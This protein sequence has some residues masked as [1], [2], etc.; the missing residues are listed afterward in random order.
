MASSL[1]AQDN[2]LFRQLLS[3]HDSIAELR[4]RQRYSACLD[5]D[6]DEEEDD[7]DITEC[8]GH[9]NR[10]NSPSL[11]S[12]SDP[13]ELPE[14]SPES[15]LSSRSSLSANSSDFKPRKYHNPCSSHRNRY[16]KEDGKQRHRATNNSKDDSRPL[17]FIDKSEICFRC[18]KMAPLIEDQVLL[19]VCIICMRIWN[20]MILEFICKDLILIL[21]TKSSY[22]IRARSFEVYSEKNLLCNI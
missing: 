21:I 1:I 10:H 15:T 3:L 17:I 16:R 20:P 19:L 13:G 14:T 12:L 18:R 2:D 8:P 9:R 6:D 7:I 11:E 22:A 5:D 4:E